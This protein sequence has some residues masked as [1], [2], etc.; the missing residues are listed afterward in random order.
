M[1]RRACEALGI[2]KD[3]AAPYHPQGKARIERSFRTIHETFERLQPGFCGPDNTGENR[4]DPDRDFQI[5]DG[6]WWD[7]RFDRPLHTLETLNAGL[8]EWT[9][10]YHARQHDSLGMSP[11]SM[12]GLEMRRHPQANVEP[13]AD[14]LFQ[15]LLTPVDRLTRRVDG[16]TVSFQNLPYEHEL[17]A[18]FA[19]VLVRYAHHDLSRVWCF[20]ERGALICE[21]TLLPEFMVNSG[22]SRRD[23]QAIK[24]RHRAQS[25][26]ERAAIDSVLSRP[27]AAQDL[28]DRLHE[29]AAGSA[30]TLAG[31]GG[32]VPAPSPWSPP[33]DPEQEK[34]SQVTIGGIPLRRAAS[35]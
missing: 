32:A 4:V 10:W 21:A 9:A 22:L 30:G 19:K 16:R 15:T 25:Q 12:W 11:E 20:D 1:A 6:Q 5:R 24:C 29:A 13:A 8:V 23:Y 3:T 2:V 31:S 14:V 17:L 27:H 26:A 33:V 18:G 35:R 7:R 28:H 34:L